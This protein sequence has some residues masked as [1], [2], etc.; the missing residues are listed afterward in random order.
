MICR[1]CPVNCELKIEKD[2][3][4]SSYRVSGNKCPQGHKY[5]LREIEE[6]SRVLFS[7]VLLE[8]APMSRLH[9]KTDALVPNSL[10]EDF[11]NIIEKTKVRA[12][13]AKGHIIIEN[14]LDT[15]INIVSAR[16]VNS[17]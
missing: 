17:I 10:K 1:I 4:N 16:R 11:I 14:I 5:A 15:G 12:P 13:V 2:E 7:R 6:P 9:V 3:A 8:N